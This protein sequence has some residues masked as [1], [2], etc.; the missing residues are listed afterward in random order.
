MKAAP[1]L[2]HSALLVLESSLCG[3][4]LVVGRRCDCL[5]EG[6]GTS[7]MQGR[8]EAS[9]RPSNCACITGQTT[10]P[11]TPRDELLGM[12]K[13]AIANKLESCEHRRV[14]LGEQR[15]YAVQQSEAQ[16]AEID[17]KMSHARNSLDTMRNS[18]KDERAAAKQEVQVLTKEVHELEVSLGKMKG[19][20]DAQFSEWYGLNK[21]LKGKLAKLSAGC[22]TCSSTHIEVLMLQP[23]SRA[24]LLETNPDMDYMYETAHK[25][26]TCEMEVH[27]LAA[28]KEQADAEA[29]HAAIA[30]VGNE[31]AVERALADQQRLHKV[32][33]AKPRLEAM[34]STKKTL[35]KAEEDQKQRIDKYEASNSALREQT[36]QL[37]T[38]LKECGCSA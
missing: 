13:V 32:L 10:Y 17:E 26:E 38:K 29:R 11:S 31:A 34:R 27:R 1:W 14:N 21:D 9:R 4:A 3:N 20:Y 24:L 19:D 7:L 23:S 22:G 6:H 16:R 33:S 37:A 25:V 15:D 2:L 36:D 18:S 30:S 8:M 28:E 35:L 5:D 12:G